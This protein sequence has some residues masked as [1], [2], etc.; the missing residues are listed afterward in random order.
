MHNASIHALALQRCAR[1]VRISRDYNR[2]AA[3]R[4]RGAVRAAA[5]VDA[6]PLKPTL[7][8]W[9]RGTQCTVGLDVAASPQ[10]APVPGRGRS[11]ERIG[12][13]RRVLYRRS[14]SR[15][16]SAPPAAADDGLRSRTTTSESSKGLMYEV[17][18]STGARQLTWDCN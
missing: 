17:A 18:G 14:L 8:S 1:L 11:G 7:R 15:S 6:A 13:A 4:P 2:D 16:F 3:L 12:C 5:C 10:A 9:D